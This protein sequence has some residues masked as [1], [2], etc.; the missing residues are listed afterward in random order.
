MNL[1]KALRLLKNPKMINVLLRFHAG[2]YLRQIGWFESYEGQKPVDQNGQPIPWVTYSFIDFISDRLDKT[3]SL[4]EYGSGNSTLFYG[5]RVKT[6]H[7]VEN[8]KDWFDLV[9]KS[10]PA[11]VQMKYIELVRG[12]DYS[13]YGQQ[14]PN[15][16]DIVIVDGRDRVNCLK[17]SIDA[18]TSRGVMILDDS[19]REEYKEALT[20][21]NDRGFRKID[22]SGVAPGV[23]YRKST[24]I[25]YRDNNCMKI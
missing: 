19:E 8:D 11:N 21:M 9:S 12:G 10:M 3:M 24:T 22:F 7:A 1:G 5:S 6:V 4:L 18:L 25:F 17:S 20:F 13:K 15:T 23:F 14:F 2:G 16:F